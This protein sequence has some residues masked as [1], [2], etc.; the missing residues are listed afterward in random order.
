MYIHTPKIFG[1]SFFFSNVC[2]PYLLL[3]VSQRMVTRYKTKKKQESSN[4][5]IKV[6][7]RTFKE[8]QKWSLKKIEC[9]SF[10]TYSCF[11]NSKKKKKQKWKPIKTRISYTI[12]KKI[13]CCYFFWKEYLY[14]ERKRKYR[15]KQNWIYLFFNKQKK[16]YYFHNR[17]A[18]GESDCIISQ[19]CSYLLKN[20]CI[21]FF[22]K[23][24]YN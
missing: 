5:V 10:K 19:Y 21:I 11:R 6:N 18:D 17:I 13:S 14:F 23:F 9:A 20:C 15:Y 22:C 4:T 3:D 7:W 2:A 16:Q 1:L 24:N 12:R 8:I